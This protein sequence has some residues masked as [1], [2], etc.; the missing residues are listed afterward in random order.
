MKRL[1]DEPGASYGM[2]CFGW[3]MSYVSKLLSHITLAH[4]LLGLLPHI[5]PVVTL[6]YNSVAQCPSPDMCSTY[7]LV[8]LLNDLL[9]LLMSL[10]VIHFQSIFL[11]Y[12]YLKKTDLCA[13]IW[14]N[15]P[16]FYA[17]GNSR[18]RRIFAEKWAA[19]G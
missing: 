10:K 4:K 5:W 2:E 17:A 12:F 16:N 13:E 18:K 11:I 19:G 8:N 7:A 6:S 15:K 1:A 9:S 14:N 3:N